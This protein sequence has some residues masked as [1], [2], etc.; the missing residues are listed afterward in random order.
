MDKEIIKKIEKLEKRL[1]IAERQINDTGE[2]IASYKA[3]LR[4]ASA[5]FF[6]SAEYKK[7]LKKFNKKTN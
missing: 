6:M 7:E 4:S 3:A 5:P 1:E 2:E